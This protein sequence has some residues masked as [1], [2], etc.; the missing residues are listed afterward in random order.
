M[1]DQTDFYKTLAQGGGLD[2]L[3]QM[4]AL[5]EEQADLE[6]QLQQAQA[7]RTPGPQRYG[8]WG[9]GL[10]A[11][12]D[13]LNAHTSKRDSAKIRDRRAGNRSAMT[14]V[15]AE[16]MN[17]YGRGL[18]QMSP[19]T[20]NPVPMGLGDGNVPAAFQFKPRVADLGPDYQGPLA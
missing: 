10:Q 14:G 4:G 15:R 18:G 17:A 13:I 9:A 2:R 11:G 19:G 7:L 3:A 8:G 20:Y 5:E 16:L 6:E 1:R 12:A